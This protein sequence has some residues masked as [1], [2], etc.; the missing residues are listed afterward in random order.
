M[1]TTPFFSIVMPVYNRETL[2]GRAIASCL[3]QSFDDFEVVVVDDGSSDGTVK[4][5][6]RFDDPRVRLLRHETNRGVCPARNTAMADA[7]GRWLVFLDSD[8]EL[9]PGALEAI[10]RRAAAVP[11]DVGGLRFACLDE[12]GTSPDPPHD[13]RIWDYADYLRWCDRVAPDRQETLPCMRASLYPDVQYPDNRALEMSFHLDLFRSTRVMACSDVVRRYHHDAAERASEPAREA[14]DRR[15]ADMA[16]A[17][18]TIVRNHGDALRRLAPLTYARFVGGA[19]TAAFLARRR[20]EGLRY[21]LTA[22]RLQPFAAR[23]YVILLAGLGG[24]YPLHVLQWLNRRGRAALGA[25]RA[26]RV[27]GTKR[28]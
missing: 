10:A 16:E 19:A 7:R 17:N 18:Q 28:V 25:V 12:R 1:T 2:V 20:R 3:T 27:R 23:N 24:A 4:A 8:D 22:I 14:L 11:G 15:A 5:V 26:T 6:E 9:L 21:S 13:D